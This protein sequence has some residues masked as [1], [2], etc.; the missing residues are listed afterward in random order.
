VV[1]IIVPGMEAFCYDKT[2]K[3]TRLYRE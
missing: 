3:G 2:R 1:R